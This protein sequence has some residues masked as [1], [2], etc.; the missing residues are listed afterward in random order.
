VWKKKY[1][2]RVGTSYWK[3]KLKMYCVKARY[4]GVE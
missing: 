4:E 1:M 3:E 2:Q